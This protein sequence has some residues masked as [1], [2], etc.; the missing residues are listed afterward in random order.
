VSIIDRDGELTQTLTQESF[1]LSHNHGARRAVNPVHAAL[2]YCYALL[3]SQCRQALSK[4]SFDVACGF[5]HADKLYRDSLVYDLMELYRAKVDSLVW[6][7][8]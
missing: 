4:Q 1:P 6:K 2:N 3:E 7:R 8:R 5:L